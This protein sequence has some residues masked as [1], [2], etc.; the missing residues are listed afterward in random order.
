M[1]GVENGRLQVMEGLD[2]QKRRGRRYHTQLGGKR[3]DAGTQQ[4]DLGSK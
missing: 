2:Y 1:A 4:R 3:G